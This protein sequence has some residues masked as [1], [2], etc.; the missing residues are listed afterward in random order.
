M[1]YES[2]DTLVERLFTNPDQKAEDMF[3]YETKGAKISDSNTG[4][5]IYEKDKV[6]FPKDWSQRAVNIVSSKYF[7]REGVPETGEETDIRQMVSRYTTA[8]RNFGEKNEYFKDSEEADTF[9]EELTYLVLDQ[10]Y[11]PNSP[12]WFNAGKGDIYGIGGSTENGLFFF[13]EET[14]QVEKTNSDYERPQCSACFI[15]S[16]EDKMF[17][18][19]SI[20]DWWLREARLFKF[21]SGS[22]ASLKNVRGKGEKLSGGGESSGSLSFA[23]VTDVIANVV[24]S[25]GITRRAAKMLNQ[26]ITH[27]DIVPFIDWKPESEKKVRALVASG[28]YTPDEAYNHVSGQNANMSV[29]IPDEFMNAAKEGKNVDFIEVTTGD[30]RGSIPASEL[31]LHLA[32]A[33]H[34]SGDP[35]VQFY[36]TM[37]LW[38]TV[39]NSGPINGS[40]PCSEY[41]FLDDSSCNLGSLNIKKFRNKEG[42]FDIKSFEH[43]ARV[44]AL[45]QEI[46]VG[47][48]G[49]PSEDIALNTHLFRPLG[50]GHANGGATLM[51]HGIPYD[52]DYGREFMAAITAKLTATVYD[53]SARIA[54]RKGSFK[55][56]EENR[57]PF[58]E[59]IG[60]HKEAAEKLN[61][62]LDGPFNLGEI[63]EDVYS[64]WET[65]QSLGV[66][67]GYRNAQGTV[68]APTGTIGFMMDVDTTG[69]EPN[70]WLIAY[71]LLVGGG[72]EVIMGESISE[73]LRSLN[74][75][76]NQIK[77][78]EK[79]LL[80]NNTLEGAPHIKEE[81]LPV[82]DAANKSGNAERYLHY[83]AHLK[84]MGAVQP[85]LS[86][87]ISKTVNLPEEASIEE[88]IEI[89]EQSHE[90]GLK[91]IAVYRDKS[92]LYQPLIDKNGTDEEAL[93]V[94]GTKVRL[95]E[96]REGITNVTSIKNI[97]QGLEYR[98]HMITGEYPNGDIGE[99]RIQLSKQGSDTRKN[100]DDIGILISETMKL[101]GD[102]Q[103]LADKF[104]NSSSN[105]S[106]A[107]TDPL[108]RSCTSM[109]DYIFRRLVLEYKGVEVYRELTEDS[110][111]QLTPQQ[112]R[113]L[114]VNRNKEIKHAQ[115]YFDDISDIN[116]KMELKDME[117]VR[118]YDAERKERIEKEKKKKDKNETKRLKRKTSS[119]SSCPKCGA[120]L[121][122]DGKCKKCANCGKTIGG[123]SV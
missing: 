81:D 14:G 105:A 21:G 9:Q 113:E 42:V 52:S 87:A 33:T 15:L 106:G 4:K 24:K 27:P 46:V 121:I 2:S 47:Y 26:Y 80:E 39:K 84:M 98:I 94:W 16:L 100:Y 32:A 119:G 62:N 107:T 3:Q 43:A 68:L 20:T 102:L 112:E 91:A 122:P 50:V 23:E 115:I 104:V 96:R 85:F 69:V 1:V 90:L 13:N 117:G 37:N 5:T 71:K 29:L 49:F 88:I 53:E 56:F 82:F 78:M 35:G 34:V 51:S 11:S 114:R 45:A 70:P 116:R 77:E 67:Y 111:F 63:V 28:L 72:T 79:F 54:K 97:T 76:E 8:L 74:Y 108:I 48:G 41:M 12:T 93:P 30:V 19:N 22:G 123:C 61:P 75:E 92:K 109:E 31:L 6:T 95:E 57:E 103:S 58:L 60:M 83:M 36:D 118:A 55:K 64:S 7:A 59:V 73:G 44:A 89:Y 65:A 17:G 38:N 99:T 10:R 86:G 110:E 66:E 101:G 18:D 40:N 25:G 120:V